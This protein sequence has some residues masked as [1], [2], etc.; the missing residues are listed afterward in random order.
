MKSGEASF[1]RAAAVNADGFRRVGISAREI[2]RV[3][4]ILRDAVGLSAGNPARSRAA[5]ETGNRD[6]IGHAVFLER[7][8]QII[9]ENEAANIRKSLLKPAHR[10][11]GD[12]FG[13][14]KVIEQRGGGDFDQHRFGVPDAAKPRASPDL[15]E[16]RRHIRQ[17]RRGRNSSPEIPWNS[18]RRVWPDR[19]R[20]RE[21]RRFVSNGSEHRRGARGDAGKTLPRFSFSRVSA[22]ACRNA[23][24]FGS[25]GAHRVPVGAHDRNR[26]GLP[27]IVVACERGTA[28]GEA[29]PMRQGPAR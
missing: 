19:R 22:S 18:R 9:F 21:D 8:A 24:Q 20:D 11:F 4:E 5:I 13:G 10:Q 26:R 28:G 27:G 12:R 29:T 15:T 7:V 14:R 1:G 2:E 3:Q 16:R 25:V 17:D 23:A 6:H